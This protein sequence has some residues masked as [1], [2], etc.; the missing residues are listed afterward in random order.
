[1]QP[2]FATGVRV[3]KVEAG[4]GTYLLKRET[5]E[6]IGATPILA[7][8]IRLGKEVD[9]HQPIVRQRREQGKHVGISFPERV[10]GGFVVAVRRQRYFQAELSRVCGVCEKS[11]QTKGCSVDYPHRLYLYDLLYCLSFSLLQHLTVARKGEAPTARPNKREI[12]GVSGE[13]IHVL[14]MHHEH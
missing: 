11:R 8:V 12:S 13:C 6:T 3:S 14:D 4:K 10:V 5:L 7:G 2:E 9:T 1:M